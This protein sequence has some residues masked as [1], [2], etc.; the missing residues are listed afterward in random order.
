MYTFLAD[1]IVAVH[2]AYVCFV[3]FGE[4]LILLGI[5][6]RWSWI[7][8]PWF[9]WIHLFM[10]LLVAVEAILQ[11]E[12]PS[13]TWENALRRMAGETITGETFIGHFL[14]NIL[15]LQ[16]EE[17]VLTTCYIGFA[18]LVAATFWLAPPR[19]RRRPA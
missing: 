15:F 3:I 13:T 12:C 11:I 1:V 4:L 16:A 14:N 10:I 9:R 5:A 6:F 2:L 8:N 17:W 7:R 18:L 19:W